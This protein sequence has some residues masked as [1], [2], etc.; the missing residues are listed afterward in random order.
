MVIPTFLFFLYFLFVIFL[1]LLF[2]F[3]SLFLSYTQTLRFVSVLPSFLFF[4][5]SSSR[6]ESDRHP[7]DLW[8]QYKVEFPNSW[9]SKLFQMIS[10]AH[11]SVPALEN[12][13]NFT[14]F[15]HLAS[16]PAGFY[17]YP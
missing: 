11:G 4:S 3:L 7:S 8:R 13:T 10:Q 16:Y 5:H 14:L 2:F 17:T 1:I 9:T 6:A 15:N 12:Q